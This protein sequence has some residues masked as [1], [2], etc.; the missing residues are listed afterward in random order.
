MEW[1]KEAEEKM[2][3]VPRAVRG[4][5]K[6]AIEKMAKKRDKEKIDAELVNKAKKKYLGKKED[7]EEKEKTKIAIVRC[8]KT[9]EVCPGIGCMNAFQDKRVKFEDYDEDARLVGFF[10]CGGCPGRRIGRLLDNLEKH[11]ERPDLVHLRSCMLYDKEQNYVKCPN[12][13]LI[14][15]MLK[16]KNYEIKEGT[17]H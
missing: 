17:H 8:E 7:S 15:N 4:M 1:K 3:N 14:K 16:S 6:K 5:A 12:I 2:Q 9:A 10:T 13:G 11:E